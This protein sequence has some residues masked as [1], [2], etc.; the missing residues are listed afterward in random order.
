M[1]EPAYDIIIIGSGAGGGT[2]AHELPR[3]ARRSCSSSAATSSRRKIRT[4]TRRRCGST[5]LSHHGAW[6]DERG[7][8]FRPYTHYCVGGNT[9]SGGACSTGFGVKIEQVADGADQRDVM[10]SSR[11]D[12][13]YDRCSR[14]RPTP[15]RDRPPSIWPPRE[16]VPLA[17]GFANARDGYIGSVRHS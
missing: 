8:E 4:G 11:V 17:K 14:S 6:L 2:L 12:C 1:P 9:N 16:P 15:T 5:S 3:P 13:W 7:Q 10:M